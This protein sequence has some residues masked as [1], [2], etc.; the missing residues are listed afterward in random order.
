MKI[1]LLLFVLAA[2]V[3]LALP[4]GARAVCTVNGISGTTVVL[5]NN[6]LGLSGVNVTLCVAS[7]GGT[8]FVGLVGVTTNSTS[9]AFAF[10]NQIGING[11]SGN[12]FLDAFSGSTSLGWGQG[13]GNCNGFDGFT[14][15]YT[16]CGQTKMGG[17]KVDTP[18]EYWTFTGTISP[19]QFVVHVAFA[20]C[21]GFFGN[22]SVSGTTDTSGQ[23]TPCPG[24]SVP[25]PGSLSLLGLGLA[26]IAGLALCRRALA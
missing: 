23:T 7:S 20:N 14:P 18:G 19:N 13:P 22:G 24:V 25:E 17:T 6:N 10:I 9:G 21:T 11:T 2:V 16:S 4:S 5:S 26:A 12:V 1:K 3:A 15:T 8:T